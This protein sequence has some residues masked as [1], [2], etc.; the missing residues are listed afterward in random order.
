MWRGASLPRDLQQGFLPSLSLSRKSPC[1]SSLIREL[2]SLIPP[3]NSLFRFRPVEVVLLP[4][5]QLRRKPCGFAGQNCA[6]SLLFSLLAGN[7]PEKG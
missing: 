7:L 2:N 3:V 4:N 1:N 6:N 5:V